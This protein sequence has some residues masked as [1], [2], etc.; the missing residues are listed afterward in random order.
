MERYSPHIYLL[1]YC[2]APVSDPA[3]HQTSTPHL[4]RV[5]TV[6]EFR[7]DYRLQAHPLRKEINALVAGLRSKITLTSEI[8]DAFETLKMDLTKILVFILNE[9][10]LISFY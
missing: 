1:F 9:T 4:N 8:T 6:K 5:E 7:K 3:Q 10:L 2:N